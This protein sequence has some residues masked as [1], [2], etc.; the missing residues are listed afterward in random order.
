MFRKKQRPPALR[1]TR[2]PP[3]RGATGAVILFN[4]PYGVLCQ[5]SGDGTRPTLKDY[6]PQ[7]DVYP[8]GRLDTDSEGL[9]VLTA[10]GTLQHRIADPRHKMEKTYWVEVEGEPGEAQLAA[11]RAGVQAGPLEEDQWCL[12][13]GSNAAAAK[14]RQLLPDLQ[15]HLLAKGLPVAGIRIR[16][17]AKQP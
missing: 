6:L 3:T 16:V 15:Q 11:L 8:A 17:Q 1:H 7:P 14:L 2:T 13:V 5:F 12:L 9:V 10:N 4:K